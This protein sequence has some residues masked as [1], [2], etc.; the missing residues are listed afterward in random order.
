MNVETQQRLQQETEAALIVIMELAETAAAKYRM[1]H[2][3]PV[4]ANEMHKFD[5]I[6]NYAEALLDEVRGSDGR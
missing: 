1:L 6:A 2:T 3:S 5:E 4:W